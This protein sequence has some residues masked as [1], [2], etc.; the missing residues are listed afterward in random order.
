[1][2][3]VVMPMATGSPGRG[4]MSMVAV[5]SRTW[6]V[7]WARVSPVALTLISERSVRVSD[8]RSLSGMDLPSIFAVMP[9]MRVPSALVISEVFVS[10]MPSSFIAV[11]RMICWL[12]L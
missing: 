7:H 5:V 8:L 1:M 6:F 4:V 3:W 11:A 2:G 9:S 10:R 12:P